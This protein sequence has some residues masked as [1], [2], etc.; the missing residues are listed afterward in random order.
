MGFRLHRGESA[1]AAFRRIGVELI[2]EM[3][4]HLD[5]R[6]AEALDVHAARKASKMI[7]AVLQLYRAGLGHSVR[8]TET[9]RFR[10]LARLLSTARDAEV[11]LATFR[12][13]AEGEPAGQRAALR[14]VDEHLAASASKG[15]P[16]SLSPRMLA[17]A[18]SALGWALLR[19]RGF[20]LKGHGWKL[21]EKG[22]RD[23]YRSARRG[24]AAFVR[25]LDGVTAHE[26]RKA[27]KALGYQVQ[28]LRCIRPRKL[29]LLH[30][31]LDKLGEVLGDHHDL[32]VLRAFLGKQPWAARGLAAM[33]PRIAQR[34]AELCVQA[35]ALAAEVLSESP[36][37]FVER[38]GTWWDD[39]R[40]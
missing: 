37:H 35:E 16:R 29:K 38:L 30:Q 31:K 2:E 7:R 4:R 26:W 19:W 21:L 22:L 6:E 20:R 36:H 18:R 5:D 27:V 9:V 17:R 1:G 32:L 14:Q 33:G 11:R 23:T 15:V 28:L 40:G 12:S 34:Q 3:G 13:I 25:E 24:H 39:W 10:E 8:R